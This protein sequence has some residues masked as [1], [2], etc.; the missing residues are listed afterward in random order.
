M[1]TH[2]TAPLLELRKLVKRYGGLVATD[3]LDLNVRQ[4]EI[5]A[6]IGPNGAGKTTLIHQI[7]GAIAPN[8]G[9]ILFQGRDITALSMHERVKLGLARSYQ[10]TNIFKACSVLDN[11]ALAV[12]A[13]RGSSMRFWRPAIADRALFDE[14]GE[15]GRRVGLGARLDV[16]AGNLAHGE[17][18]QLEVGLALATQP[19]LLLL[20]EPMAGMGPD[21]S[22]RLIPLI[23]KLRNE[24]GV[25]LIEHD[26]D[27][28]F[29]LADR[30]SVLVAGRIISTGTPDQIR[31]DSEVKKAYLGDEA[32]A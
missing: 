12:Q 30:I 32:I 2:S 7:S 5:H 8:E 24:I 23:K 17:Q 27:A 22:A 1:N 6:I 3:H 19:K 26:M 28:V 21:E 31:N 14:A 18:R 13:R 20:D 29:Q 10:I 16:I 9:S 4:G 25:V 11:I 15:V